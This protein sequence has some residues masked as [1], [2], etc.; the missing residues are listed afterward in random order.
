[1]DKL[2]KL[3]IYAETYM[4][5]ATQLATYRIARQ[6]MEAGIP[7]QDAA[8]WANLGYLPAEA[9]KLIA[10]GIGPQMADAVDEAAEAADGGPDGHL[11]AGVLRLAEQMPGLIIDPDLADR[12]GLDQPQ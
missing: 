3:A 4:A 8:A 12:L 10:Q 1:M 5:A 6:W 2:R 7:A 11:R 9:A